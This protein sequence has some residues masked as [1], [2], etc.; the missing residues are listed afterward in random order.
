MWQNGALIHFHLYGLARLMP[1]GKE[2]AGRTIIYKPSALVRC[3]LRHAFNVMI[4][5]QVQHLNNCV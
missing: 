3:V 1:H 2:T 5:H 4:R